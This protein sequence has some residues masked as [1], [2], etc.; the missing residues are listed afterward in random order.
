MQ[1]LP[2]ISAMP[3]PSREAL[4][5]LRAFQSLEGSGGL[6][7]ILPLSESR[8]ILKGWTHGHVS[9]FL[10]VLFLLPGSAFLPFSQ[11]N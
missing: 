11:W 10:L 4:W 1:I 3:S 6:P 2:C 7:R 8:Q 9:C 5:G